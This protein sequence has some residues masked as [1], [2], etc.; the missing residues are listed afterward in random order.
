M[1]TIHLIDEAG[2][3]RPY[4]LSPPEIGA[5]TALRRP[6]SR[7]AYAAA[8]VVPRVTGNNVPD[9]AA[10]IDWD[11][12]LAFR[13]HLWS[14][15][16]GVAD[17]MDT[18]QRNMGLDPTAIRS[19]IKRS[20]AE[21][22]AVGGSIVVGVNTDHLE[23]D[24][25]SLQAVIDAYIEQLEFAES[26]GAEVVLMASRHL[27]R[28]AE[29][30][31]D[32]RRV[33]RQVLSRCSSPV[34]L[35]W[36][37]PMFDPALAGYF[38]SADAPVARDT[39]EQI[40]VENQESVAGIKVSLLDG[41][42]EIALRQT[43]PADVLVFTGDDFNYVDMIAGDGETHSDALLGAFATCAPVAVTALHAL[44]RGD[45]VTFRQLLEPTQDLAREVFAPPTA[46][47]KTGVAFLSWLNGHQPAFVMVGGLQSAR[48]LPHLSRLIRLA[49]N[50][51]ALED[52]DLAASRWNSLLA[53]HGVDVPARPDGIGMAVTHGHA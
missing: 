14:C 21:A 49:D 13:H 53:L 27:A 29:G 30:P 3:T 42:T 17:A 38:G 41:D 46:F 4:E 24:V 48:S 52:P 23:D 22:Q 39:V 50:A 15:G 36:L 7:R 35:H 25:V 40:I 12:T 20:T 51:S 33:Y 9:S 43:L 19:L 10:D 11:S 45:E 6:T 26:Q 2:T 28:I 34:I 44:D 8:H 37:G 47:Y 18:A 32:Y 16:L 31:N 1:P 5:T